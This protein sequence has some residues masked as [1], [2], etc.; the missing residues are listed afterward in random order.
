MGIIEEIIFG[1]FNKEVLIYVIPIGY[2]IFL[3][4]FYGS[5]K[6]KEFSDFDKISF[7]ILTSFIIVYLIAYPIS[8]YSTIIHNIF[9]FESESN[10][11]SPNQSQ[12]IQTYVSYLIIIVAILSMIKIFSNGSL[13]ENEKIYSSISYIFLSTIL[14]L[15]IILFFLLI[16][17][18]VSGFFDYFIYIYIS[19]FWT[20][21]LLMVFLLI[22][23]SIH[24]N[25]KS[26]IDKIDEIDIVN[27]LNY[28]KLKYYHILMIMMILF[29]LF[30]VVVGLILFKPI[31]DENGQ[32]I[33]EINID[34]LPVSERS[35]NVNAE[36]IIEK[37]YIVKTKLIPW[38]KID[39]N[40]TLKSARGEVDGYYT[41]YD[42]D[43]S[44]FTAIDCS[45]KTNITVR[46]TEKFYITNEL[47]Y[48]INHP[49]FE[50][51]TEIINLTLKNNVPAIIKIRD[52]EILINENYYLSE[53]NFIK[54]QHFANGNG[55]IRGYTQENNWLYLTD[56][57][58]YKN[59]TG[60]IT[61]I[62]EK[63]ET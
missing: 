48:E 3:L 60:T 20:I 63:I 30:S 50:N 24:K 44:N 22:Y 49:S 7:S 27:K 4:Y 45:K 47:T 10:I 39:T 42:I 43:S 58:L 28:K 59:A 54:T 1:F 29:I 55:G 40:I 12:I 56:I 19:T 51:N 53:D 15:I 9:I 37:D 36:N 14:V 38:V 35:R 2:L 8:S 62:L 31:I 18:Y 26:S 46:G 17:F 33:K 61:L 34:N 32:L 41:E 6:W 52:T 16:S 5:T 21:V 57:Q 25:F 13:Y 23:S 11:I